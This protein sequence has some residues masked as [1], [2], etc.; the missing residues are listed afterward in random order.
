MITAKKQI[1]CWK[2]YEIDFK[3]IKQLCIS[4]SSSDN[5]TYMYFEDNQE[6]QYKLAKSY[7][8]KRFDNIYEDF[9]YSK[10]SF[11]NRKIKIGYIS[12]DF[13]DHPVTK[14]VFRIIQLHDGDKFDVN[15]YSLFDEIEDK[16]T[17]YVKEGVN[18]FV[19]LSYKS[20]DE[21]VDIIR[22]DNLDIAIDLMGYSK[23]SR[24]NIFAKRVAPVQISY[25][26]FPGTT[27][28]TF[29]DYIIADE[30]LIP[31]KDQ[32]FFS[33]KV[34]YL[35]Q[36]ALCCDDRLIFLEKEN[37][38]EQFGLPKNGFIFACFNNNLKI[39]P[40]VFKIWMQILQAVDNSF[41]CLYAS[42]E[43]SKKI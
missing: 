17:N 43:I 29:M 30:I 2:N 42:N 18:N 9:K 22:S 8:K 10:K 19:N 27:G 37:I 33:E 25:L 24:P 7:S 41:L 39:C 20:D 5:N 12:S 13:R 40:K 32:K 26:G 34:I 38:R 36:S 15:A 23:N 21:I 6:I 11:D 31:K 3:E 35:N 1:C 16:Y 4:Q 14:L 28:S